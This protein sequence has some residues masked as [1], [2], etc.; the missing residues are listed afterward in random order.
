MEFIAGHPVRLDGVNTIADG[1]AA[2]FAGALT[3]PVVRDLVEDVVLVSDA[4]IS[5]AIPFL[6]ARA[7][8]RPTNPQG[9]AAT[10]A[11]LAHK[12]REAS[13]RRVVA[14]LSG[15]NVDLERLRTWLPG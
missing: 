1:L 15:G 11:L 9:A 6:L 10:A 12:I 5:A 7:K 14:I 13:G 3:Y 2:L 4:G 8:L